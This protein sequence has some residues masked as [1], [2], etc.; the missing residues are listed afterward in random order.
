MSALTGGTA[1]DLRCWQA[2]KMKFANPYQLTHVLGNEALILDLILLDSGTAN[3]PLANIPN[4]AGLRPQS[5]TPIN[6]TRDG[7]RYGWTADTPAN[8]LVGW[9]GN[10]TLEQITEV[11][12]NISEMDRFILNQTEVYTYTGTTGWMQSQPGANKLLVDDF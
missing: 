12:S 1:F 7:V 3:V 6:I 10:K 9:D 2:F 11:G 5:L 4:F 8:T